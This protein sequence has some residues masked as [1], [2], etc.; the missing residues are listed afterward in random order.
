MNKFDRHCPFQPT[1]N[2]AGQTT[3]PFPELFGSTD[4]ECAIDTTVPQHR[5][6]NDEQPL[7]QLRC[8]AAK[9]PAEL[10][11]AQELVRRRYAWRGYHVLETQGAT[12]PDKT[13]APHYLTFVAKSVN[14]LVGTVTLGMDSIHGLLVDEANK[15]EADRLRAHGKR[16]CELVRLAVEDGVNSKAVLA[17]LFQCVYTMGRRVHNLTDVL[18]EVNPRHVPFYRKVFGFVC[19]SEEKMCQRVG[20]VSVLLSLDISSLEERLMLPARVAGL[21]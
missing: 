6:L 11:G 18:I 4:D 9:K 17:S 20:A 10:L 15:R 5:A 12:F 2:A 13:R 8:H 3:R 16:L 19:A 14:T 7:P 21:I 1:T